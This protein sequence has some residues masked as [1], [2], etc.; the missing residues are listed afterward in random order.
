MDSRKARTTFTQ[1]HWET[2]QDIV[3]NAEGGRFLQALVVRNNARNM[4]KA[5]VWD[6]ITRYFNQVRLGFS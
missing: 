1:R 3:I 2:L 4:S 5:E 6:D